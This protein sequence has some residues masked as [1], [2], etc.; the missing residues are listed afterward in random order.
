MKHCSS[1]FSDKFDTFGNELGPQAGQAYEHATKFCRVVG[2]NG[3]RFGVAADTLQPPQA[4]AVVV[5]PKAGAGK[6][7][8]LPSIRENDAARWC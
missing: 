7:N 3:F 6:D 8:L 2:A 4:E 1:T 5:F